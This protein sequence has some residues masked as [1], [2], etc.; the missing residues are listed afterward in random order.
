[1]KKKIVHPDDWI[2]KF[3]DGKFTYLYNTDIDGGT[4]IP[5]HEYVGVLRYNEEV[6]MFTPVKGR[7]LNSKYVKDMFKRIKKA[8]RKSPPKPD[9]RK[10][11]DERIE[12]VFRETMKECRIK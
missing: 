4:Y 6:M 9:E 11:F 1:M 5:Y 12:K 10:I 3:S 2:V 8:Q 7:E